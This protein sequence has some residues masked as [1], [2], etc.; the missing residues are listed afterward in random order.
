MLEV[1]SK[2][3]TEQETDFL[4]LMIDD[5]IEATA[6]ISRSLRNQEDEK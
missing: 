5:K 2:R 6:V 3:S 4:V 1:T